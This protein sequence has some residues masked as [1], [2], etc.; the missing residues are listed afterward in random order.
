M[1]KYLHA[2]D[3]EVDKRID[4]ILTFIGIFSVLIGSKILNKPFV[5]GMILVMLLLLVRI[6]WDLIYP[7]SR[8][9]KR[10]TVP[11]WNPLLIIMISSKSSLT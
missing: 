5:Y 7:R 9:Q 6:G 10:Y 8:E 4:N 1:K 11:I 2:I 3:E